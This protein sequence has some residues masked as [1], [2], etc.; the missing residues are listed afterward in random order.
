V[1]CMYS[2]S[3]SGAFSPH[4]DVISHSF[5]LEVN[6]SSI[7]IDIQ[8]YKYKSPVQIAGP[9]QLLQIQTCKA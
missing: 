2:A 5:L 9:D 4:R 8:C 6:K 1:M 7:P 3:A